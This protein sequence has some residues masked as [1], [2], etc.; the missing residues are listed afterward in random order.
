MSKN[1]YGQYEQV[2]GG[3]ANDLNDKLDKAIELL[4]E[5]S[6]TLMNDADVA[7]EK[8]IYDFLDECGGIDCELN[9]S[10]CKNCPTSLKPQV[11]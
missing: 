3:V 10:E 4:T 5:C 6:N 8:A 11:D 9:C 2:N 7:L 1:R